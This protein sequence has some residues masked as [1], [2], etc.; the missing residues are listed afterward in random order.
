M[1]PFEQ[2]PPGLPPGVSPHLDVRLKS[3]WRFDRSNRSFVPAIGPPVRLRG[4]LPVGT[5]IL[6]TV[7]SL[8]DAD[9]SSLSED[10]QFLARCLQVVPPSGCEPSR[11][12]ELLLRLDAVEQVE[13][14]PQIGLP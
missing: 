10:E 9:P 5:K 4:Q 14:S 11:L 3:G 7:P 13:A 2:E 8:A 1:H 12:A 6:H